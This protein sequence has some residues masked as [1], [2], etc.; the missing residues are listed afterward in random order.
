MQQTQ[1]DTENRLQ[2]E[3]EEDAESEE[4]DPERGDLEDLNLV[5]SGFSSQ[6]S[7]APSQELSE[8]VRFHICSTF[9]YG[10]LNIHLRCLIHNRQSII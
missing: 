6:F 5:D 7:V 4:Y 8:R 2:E 9:T 1:S 3:N 10:H